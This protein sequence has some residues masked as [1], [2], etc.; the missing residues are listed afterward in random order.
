MTI[1]A[2]TVLLT[3]V[4]VAVMPDWRHSAGWGYGPGVCVGLLLLGLG[5]F[6][7]L[8]RTG[9]ADAPGDRTATSVRSIMVQASME[10]E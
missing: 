8:G 5:V 2:I 10:A 3:A 1:L 4:G 6:A 9:V 7:A